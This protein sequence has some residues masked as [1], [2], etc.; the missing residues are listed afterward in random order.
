MGRPKGSRNRRT[1]DIEYRLERIGCDPIEGIAV[2]A[3]DD[4]NP[5]ELRARMYREL[6]QYVGRV[7]TC[8]KSAGGGPGTAQPLHPLDPRS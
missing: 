2:I 6:A 5:I 8:G 3:L 4:T 1:L 7:A